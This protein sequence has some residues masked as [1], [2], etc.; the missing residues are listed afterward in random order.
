MIPLAEKDITTK[1][2]ES[3]NQVFADIVNGL[4]F[5]G[6]AVLNA[7]DLTPADKDSHYKTDGKIRSQE[8]DVSKFWHNANIKIAFIGIENQVVPDELMPVRIL[9]YD[10]AVY[11]NQYR[12]KKKSKNKKCC[13]VITLV[14]YFGKEDWKYGKNLLSCLEIPP[15][16]LPFVS[17]Y[18]MNLY[19]IKDMTK[20]QIENFQSD[21][22][23]IA[24][25][26]Y[27]FNNGTDYYPTD[28]KLDYP[29][30]VLDM[31]SVFT[32]D[33]R[34]REEYNSMP[35]ETKEG[36]ISMCEIYDKILR[37]GEARGEAIGE[38]RGQAIGEARGEARG[39]LRALAELVKDGI[40]TLSDAAK[41]ADMTVD[42]FQNKTGLTV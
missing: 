28:Q 40:L 15:P 21:F 18:K 6:E 17:D 23:M 41:R 33:E 35:A 26:F 29:E 34:F 20:D 2:L 3:H 8:R 30:E 36:G 37:E 1:T 16:L 39:F 14:I 25:F 13:P 22:R 31:I 32:G 10:G 24:E 5:G 9:S 27:A 11:R 19:S 12:Q 4:L 7:D 42:E 38:A